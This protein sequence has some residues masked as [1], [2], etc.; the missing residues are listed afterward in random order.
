MSKSGKGEGYSVGFGKPPEQHRFKKGQSG[1]PKGRSK[2]AKVK[3]PPPKKFG[4]GYLKAFLQQEAFRD[5]QLHENGKPVTLSAVQAIL[6]S[7]LLDGVKGNRLAK[8]QAYELLMRTEREAAEKSVE[9][10]QFWAAYKAEKEMTIQKCR[11]EGSPIPQIYPHPD[12]I[13]LDEANV[14]VHFLGPQSADQAIPYIRTALMRD[15]LIARLVLL[16]R[17][18][19]RSI[20][21]DKEGEDQISANEIPTLIERALPPSFQRSE[22]EMRAFVAT[23]MGLG[24][25]QLH[26]QMD[27]LMRE[28]EGLPLTVEERLEQHKKSIVVL[29][30]LGTAFEKVA[31]MLLKKEAQPA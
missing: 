19:R 23:L 11:K 21:P 2:K 7:L 6:R 5:L 29:E 27:A 25:R 4:E 20:S 1:N 8:R 10:Y 13:L 15:W 18:G 31:E 17:Y 22:S 12:D 3:E 30:M 14:A 24:K 28:S 9:N 26:K 16:G